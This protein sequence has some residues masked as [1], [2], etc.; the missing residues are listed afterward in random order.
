MRRSSR[1]W[2]GARTGRRAGPRAADRDRALRPARA[3]VRG[4][5]S[6]RPPRPP[7]A[8]RGGALRRPPRAAPRAPRD[9][10]ARRGAAGGWELVCRAVL[11]LL[12]IRHAESTWN[13]L[14]RWQGQADPPLSE[15][16]R[17]AAVALAER[18]AG[19]VAGCAA[20]VSSDLLRARETAG[21]LAGVLAARARGLA[22]AARG[23]HRQLER[24]G[25]HG[26]RGALARG[27]SPLPRRRSGAAAGR[28]RE[29]AR[30][31]PARARGGA[32]ARASL[33]RRTR[34]RRHAPRL[35]PRSRAGAPARERG[36]AVARE[37][38]ARRDGAA[39]GARRRRYEGTHGRAVA[40]GPRCRARRARERLLARAGR[41]AVAAR[42]RELALAPS[43]TGGRGLGRRRRGTDGP[44]RA[45]ARPVRRLRRRPADGRHRL[46]PPASSARSS[47]SRT[48]RRDRWPPRTRRARRWRWP[49]TRR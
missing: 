9:P 27:L 13:A 24:T 26:D 31:A 48:R 4:P 34:R 32:G 10:R 15:A 21:I 22:A 38:Q 14:G 28:R 7:P 39:R 1:P 3:A 42:R 49:P 36:Y 23:R 29:P 41:R 12:C 20:L 37:R 18:L 35:D 46:Q 6:R 44:A 5:R 30:P 2:P 43:R 40:R 33:R 17:R 16:G 45:R 19:E 25:E 11:R 8:A 47:R